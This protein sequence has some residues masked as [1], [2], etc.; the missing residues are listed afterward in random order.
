MVLGAA[1]HLKCGFM[2]RIARGDFSHGGLFMTVPLVEVSVIHSGDW[3]APTG[4]DSLA[5][6]RLW[7]WRVTHQVPSS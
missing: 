3:S 2:E 7:E 5:D 6:G 4:S 1:T